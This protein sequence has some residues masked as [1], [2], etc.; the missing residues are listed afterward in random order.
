MNDTTPGI[1]D[2][3][4][5]VPK[6][7]IL[8]EELDLLSTKLRAR[9]KEI[10]AAVPRLPAISD[11]VTETKVTD[12]AGTVKACIDA[13]DEMRKERGKDPW[14][15][16]KFINSYFGALIEQLAG[17]DYMTKK[18]AG[19][20]FGDLKK[21]L[22]NYLLEQE[23]LAAAERQRLEDAARAERTAAAA[24]QQEAE[25]LGA[26]D[27]FGSR[28]EGVEAAERADEKTVSAEKLE[29]EAASV[30]AL[31]IARGSYGTSAGKR[32]RMLVEKIEDPDVALAH[33][34]T[35]NRDPIDEAVLKIYQAQA[36]AGV[37]SLPGAKLTP[38]T[39]VTIRK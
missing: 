32:T 17:P 20:I 25:Q 2:N 21:Q 38:V 23:R 13:L 33:A 12:F 22:G 31:T 16:Y 6:E 39:S 10:L 8:A 34:L 9:L 11:G 4:Q 36:T 3:A 37:K 35:L 30:S 26:K 29:Q 1:G 24:A 5:A 18:K 7:E 28:L 15:E 19:G 27:D 14:D